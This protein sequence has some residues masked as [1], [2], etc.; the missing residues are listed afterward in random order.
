MFFPSCGVAAIHPFGALSN[1]K[2][3]SPSADGDQGFAFGNH[4]LL[5]K[6]DQNF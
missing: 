6:L 2:V 1:D 4:E 5:K 3:I